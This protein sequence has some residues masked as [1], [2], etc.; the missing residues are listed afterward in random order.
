[1]DAAVTIIITGQKTQC[2]IEIL[3][4]QSIRRHSHNLH[5]TKME[6]YNKWKKVRMYLWN[7]SEYTA[8]QSDLTAKPRRHL[9]KEEFIVL[10][11]SFDGRE[12]I[13]VVQEEPDVASAHEWK[14]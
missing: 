7:A 13:K 2:N 10:S 9:E 4:E 1:M 11:S 12:K 14:D 6:P 3:Q 5:R 8:E